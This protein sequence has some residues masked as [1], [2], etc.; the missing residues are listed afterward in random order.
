MSREDVAGRLLKGKTEKLTDWETDKSKPTVEQARKLAKAYRVPLPFL[1]LTKPPP[2][3]D[4][5]PDLRT[6]GDRRV[7]VSPTLRDVVRSAKRKQAW[8]QDVRRQNEIDPIGFVGSCSVGDGVEPV[9]KALRVA[10]GDSSEIRKRSSGWEEYFRDLSKRAESAGV[11]VLRS[12]V[13]GNNSH[14]SIET[15]DFR[16][17]ALVDS[18][19]PVIF[20]NTRDAPPARLFTLV[21]ELAHLVI[22]VSG[23]S[24]TPV[25][26]ENELRFRDEEV[27]C[28]A[29]AA[30]FLTP[31]AEFRRV[32]LNRKSLGENADRLKNH[33]RVSRLVIARRALDLGLVSRQTFW[34]VAKPILDSVATK[35]RNRTP[36][37][38]PPKILVP[39]RNGHF[40]TRAV[41]AAAR[42]GQLQYREAAALLDVRP[43]HIDQLAQ[44]LRAGA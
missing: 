37:A 8:L 32:W 1:Y 39:S 27:F 11:L 12:S 14:R 25:A 18:L 3:K 6:V 38:V 19:A 41:I 43:K 10:L 5:L 34:S 36:G 29:V 24:N 15:E 2:D 21:H 22:G 31:E 9:V 13:V 16:G 23:V 42:A 30:E 26:T 40:F 35:K 4:P 28:N 44:A 33:F 7:P 17:F 20:V